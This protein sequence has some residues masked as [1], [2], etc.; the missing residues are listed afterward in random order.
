[1]KPDRFPSFVA[2]IFA[3]VILGQCNYVT[4]Y[5]LPDTGQTQCYNDVGRVISCPAPGE[6]FYGQDGNY[7]GPQPAYQDN[8]DGTVP[9][10]NTGL[11][12]QRGDDQNDTGYGF[13]WQDAVN[14]CS[15]LDLGGKSDW[16]LPS[17]FEL[18]SLVRY[19]NE[20]P[21][22]NTVYFPHVHWR[23]YWSNT[24]IGSS[25]DA[26]QWWT[27][28]FGSGADGLNTN[29]FDFNYLLP[30]VRCVRGESLR[31]GNYAD[32]HNGTVIDLDTGLVWQQG[33][34]QNDQG[35]HSWETALA[36]CEDL[37]LGGWDDWRLPNIQ[38]IK[39]IV[40][41]SRLEPAINPIFGSGSF[42]LDYWS[43]TTSVWIAQVDYAQSVDFSEGRIQHSRKSSANY[44]R[45]V[46]GGSS[47]SAL[48]GLT[49]GDFNGDGKAELVGLTTAGQ[50][51]YSM[52]LQNW[53][54][55]PGVLSQI[56]KGDL[57]GNGR[58]DLIGITV[59]GHIYYALNLENWQWMPGVLHEIS[60]G[61]LNGDGK[62]D[63]M[64]IA[65]DGKVYYT[66]DLLNWIQMM[67]VAEN[68]DD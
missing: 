7:T 58:E 17:Q 5:I 8:G 56:T 30:Y 65:P 25:P 42:S 31:Q 16:R 23:I 26:V 46:R 1:M 38:E 10:L 13:K 12:W 66:L 20:Q 37:T 9:D 45:C 36:Y 22:I 52:D 14:Y 51:F 27:V 39:T 28:N 44:V 63:V 35:G 2:A 64:G 18:R 6:R 47:S 24:P 67:S 33:D 34:A 48:I 15:A 41:Y 60:T 4:A 40:D 3:L 57:D 53:Q 54:W 29:T 50:L 43:S 49:G 11:V 59:L 32:N 62:D 21:A 61:D 19:G 68:T 55:M